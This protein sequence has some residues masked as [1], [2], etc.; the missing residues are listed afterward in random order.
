M[1]RSICDTT[2]HNRQNNPMVILNDKQIKQKLRRLAFE[3]IEQ[4]SSEP[5]IILAGVNNN[6]YACAKLLKAELNRA[7]VDDIKITLA[8]INLNPAQP[9]MD[10]VS[11]DLSD[12]AIKDKVAIVIDDVANTG[13][14]L[15]YACL[16]FIHTLVKKLQTA[17]LVDRTH[18][19]YPVLVNY[20]GLSLATTL[21]DHIQVDLNKK[22]GFQATVE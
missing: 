4:N 9:T 8:Q 1:I 10:E 3:I 11:I 17:V 18:K 2:A 5:E 13:R 22:S 6:G 14:T 7:K 12:E 19:S 20:I 21:K 16:P 15:F